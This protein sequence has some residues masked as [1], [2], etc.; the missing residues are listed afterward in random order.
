MIKLKCKHCKYQYEI[1]EAELQDNGELYRY[2]LMCGGEIEILNLVEII[3]KD[4]ETQIRKNIDKW[5][6][7]LGIEY[8]IEMCERNKN[9]ACYK[10]YKRELEKRGF[11]LKGGIK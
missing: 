3:A 5:F 8:T 1:S 7:E 11:K 6:K 2:C 9:N 4:L 10:L